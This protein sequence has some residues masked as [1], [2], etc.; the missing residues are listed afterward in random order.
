MSDRGG[1]GEMWGRRSATGTVVRRSVSRVRWDARAVSELR[2]VHHERAPAGEEHRDSRVED[3]GFD[4]RDRA[5]DPKVCRGAAAA[6]A[7]A[8]SQCLERRGARAGDADY[9]DVE[10]RGVAQGGPNAAAG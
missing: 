9:E 4:Q 6:E 3:D 2:G 8:K 1:T 7:G 10:H 5:L